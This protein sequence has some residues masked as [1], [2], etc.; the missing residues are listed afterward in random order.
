MNFG[1]DAYSIEVIDNKIVFTGELEKSDYTEI[2][3]FLRKAESSIE[4]ENITI[5]IK[6]LEFLNSSGIRAIGSFLM[7][8]KKKFTICLD[9]EISWQRIG[10]M[11]LK[12]LRAPG[13]IEIETK[14]S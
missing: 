10:I 12:A 4:D 3:N 6:E 9:Q 13:E 7:K 5:D 8:S 11:P 1:E 14:K 2:N